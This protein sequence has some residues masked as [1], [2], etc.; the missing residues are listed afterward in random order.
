[1][2]H[3]GFDHGNV[4][5]WHASRFKRGCGKGKCQVRELGIYGIMDAR[6]VHG[7]ERPDHDWVIPEPR[8]GCLIINGGG[9]FVDVI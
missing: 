8:N 6:E 5:L 9:F 2:P 4:V 1:M 7:V 3:G